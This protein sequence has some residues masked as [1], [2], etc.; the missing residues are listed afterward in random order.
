MSLTISIQAQEEHR[1]REPIARRFLTPKQFCQCFVS[2]FIA[3]YCIPI[4]WAECDGDDGN[5]KRWGKPIDGGKGRLTVLYERMHSC[6][7]KGEI[8]LIEEWRVHI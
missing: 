8:F 2:I 5:P 4:D 7:D 3:S 1:G 6:V